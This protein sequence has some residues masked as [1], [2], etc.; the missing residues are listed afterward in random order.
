[1][2]DVAADAGWLRTTL[3][4]IQLYQMVIQGRW[5]TESTL[6]QLPRF[7]QKLVDLCARS[8]IEFIPQISSLPLK[9]MELLLS[10]V[11]NANEK[12]VA[13]IVKVASEMPVIDLSWKLGE[14][15]ARG[16]AT[17]SVSLTRKTK[18]PKSGI[19]APK[20]PKRMQEAWWLVV[21]DAEAGELIA[22]R[23]LQFLQKTTTK[24]TFE[25]P[26]DEPGAE[27]SV[28]LYLLSDSYIGFDQ[29]YE[30]SFT[31]K[32]GDPLEEIEEGAE[33]LTEDAAEEE[34]KPIVFQRDDKKTVTKKLEGDEEGFW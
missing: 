15:K 24:L 7:S 14:T 20:F 8:G 30:I 21:G 5:N 31:V 10:K 13:S 6:F 18:W 28:V 27:R 22:L 29:Q 23:R 17:L 4:I 11:L 1:M 3:N 34:T 33:E 32:E 26:N 12:K 25:V 16:E 9:K 2:C 19:Y